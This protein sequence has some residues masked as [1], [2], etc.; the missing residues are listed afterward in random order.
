VAQLRG[1]LNGGYFCYFDI[2]KNAIIVEMGASA[3]IVHE[4]NSQSYQNDHQPTGLIEDAKVMGGLAIE[5]YKGIA[6]EAAIAAN[7]ATTKALARLN[8]DNISKFGEILTP[9]MDD[10]LLSF[11]AL[12]LCKLSFVAS[13]PAPVPAAV[14]PARQGQEQKWLQALEIENYKIW[15]TTARAVGPRSDLGDMVNKLEVKALTTLKELTEKEFAG[16]LAITGAIP[17]LSNTHTLS[18]P[19]VVFRGTSTAADVLDTFSS[20]LPETFTTK[21]GNNLGRTGLGFYNHYTALR[22]TTFTDDTILTTTLRKFAQNPNAGILVAGHGLG[23]AAAAL[24]AGEIYSDYK[25]IN[26]TLVTF[27]IPGNVFDE[28]TKNKLAYKGLQ[29]LQFIDRGDKTI[30]V[31]STTS[32]RVTHFANA[33]TSPSTPA[34]TIIQHADKHLDWHVFPTVDDKLRFQTQSVVNAVHKFALTFK[35]DDISGKDDAYAR[36]FLESKSFQDALFSIKDALLRES[37]AA[38]GDLFYA[39]LELSK[40]A[41]IT[42]DFGVDASAVASEPPLVR[43]I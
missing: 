9:D 31:A 1:A 32:H 13:I 3:S 8:E 14:D 21:A 19:F 7:V 42:A 35:G 40:S 23:A 12:A 20:L 11:K 38:L 6:I 17:Y 41:L 24:F 33:I 5:V 43:L 18:M 15:Y 30:G 36:I 22:D 16:A 25:H 29:Q 4:Q 37:F 26:L 27:G 34:E 28:E 10:L 2:S 39:P